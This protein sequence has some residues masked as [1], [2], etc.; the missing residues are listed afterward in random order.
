M[1]V[2]PFKQRGRVVLYVARI[3]DFVIVFALGVAVG[4]DKLKTQRKPPSEDCLNT[5]SVAVGMLSGW[6]WVQLD[7]KPASAGEGER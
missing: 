2:K 3:I 7:V 6:N 5:N 1:T 4:H